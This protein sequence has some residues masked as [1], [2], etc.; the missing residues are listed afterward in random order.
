MAF[1]AIV[2]FLKHQQRGYE[3]LFGRP[4]MIEASPNI[5]VATPDQLNEDIG[6][7]R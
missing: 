3:R 5:G 7:E 2:E 1:S 4:R 6:V